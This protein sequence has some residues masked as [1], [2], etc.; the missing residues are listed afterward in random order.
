MLRR[1]SRNDPLVVNLESKFAQTLHGSPRSRLAFI[2]VF[3][4]LALEVGKL[5]IRWKIAEHVQLAEYRVI[6]AD[7]DSRDHF[8]TTSAAFRLR[9]LDAQQGVM[10]GERQ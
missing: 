4:E 1:R 5:G 10:I 9:N 2:A 6:D 7:F 8:D 3:G